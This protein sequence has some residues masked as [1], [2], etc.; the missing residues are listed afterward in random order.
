LVSATAQEDEASRNNDKS[1]QRADD[2]G[3]TSPERHSAASNDGSSTRQ[4]DAA[5]IA[6]SAEADDV[7]KR[8]MG[9]LR[10]GRAGSRQPS[11]RRA[12]SALRLGRR[13][14][15]T[16]ATGES[17][18]DAAE[19]EKD[20]RKSMSMLRLG[21]AGQVDQPASEFKEEDEKRRAMSALRLGRKRSSIDEGFA[22]S[23]L[24]GD[25]TSDEVSDESKRAMGM[26]RL[27][28]NLDD[29]SDLESV[30]LTSTNDNEKRAMGMLRLGRQSL[31]APSRID[32]R[33]SMAMLRLG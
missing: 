15:W 32:R 2:S 21:R 24:N 11:D 10:L 18:A 4:L 7:T 30:D 5:A 29:G 14:S 31:V 27:G 26:L 28:R 6:E 22:E 19:F 33:K 8:A 3:M 9:M 23:Q 16:S 17:A 1:E 25:V 13:N 20:K 12:M